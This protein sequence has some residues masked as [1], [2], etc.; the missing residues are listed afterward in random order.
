MQPPPTELVAAPG[1][2]TF[3]GRPGITGAQRGR[4]WRLWQAE[5]VRSIP[6]LGMAVSVRGGGPIWRENR[7]VAGQKCM[8]CA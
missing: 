3:G 1:S 5:Q 7:Q 6:C 2:A 8:I 4:F